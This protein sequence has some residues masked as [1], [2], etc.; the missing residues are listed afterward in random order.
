MTKPSNELVQYW[1]RKARRSGF[2]CIERWRDLN[3]INATTLP[4]RH[5]SIETVNEYKL[6]R[7]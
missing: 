5:V 2:R 1:Y 3:K 6:E 4:G 7:N